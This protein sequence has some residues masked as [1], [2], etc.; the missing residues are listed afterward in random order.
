L[1][2]IVVLHFRYIYDILR[3]EVF[4]DAQNAPN[5]FFAGAL[6]RTQLGELTTLP[7][8]LVS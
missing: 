7:R 5:L 3:T 6:P 4:C 8:P 1:N 2:I